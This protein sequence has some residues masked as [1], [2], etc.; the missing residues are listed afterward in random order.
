MSTVFIK[1]YK[2]KVNYCYF[3]YC[4]KWI[5]EFHKQSPFNKHIKFLLFLFLQVIFW[6][7][8]HLHIHPLPGADC[9][10]IENWELFVWPG[11]STKKKDEQIWLNFKLWIKL[12]VCALSNQKLEFVR[13]ILAYFF[14]HFQSV[15]KWK[16]RS[17]V[18]RW[19]FRS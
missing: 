3:E 7:C 16:N 12:T 5:L 2:T 19:I 4:N 11:Q 8:A 10:N 1:F 13:T 14:L 18:A 9:I 17:I 15:W 6:L